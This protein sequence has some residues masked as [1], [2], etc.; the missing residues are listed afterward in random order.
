M[1]PSMAPADGPYRRRIA[2]RS[3]YHAP[4]R[5]VDW[6]L[7]LNLGQKLVVGVAVPVLVF[8][9]T[10]LASLLIL[11]AAGVG[12]ADHPTQGGPQEGAMPAPAS[13]R[14]GASASAS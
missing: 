4:M 7:G 10:Y 3:G 14:P 1:R 8:V 9:L 6:Y 12:R 11:S 13:L 5:L 2:G